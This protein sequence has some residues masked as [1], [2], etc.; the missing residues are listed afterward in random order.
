MPHLQA[1]QA[2][3]AADAAVV[4][5][6]AVDHQRGA[7][8]Q[9]ARGAQAHAL[10]G[11]LQL[12]RRGQAQV[13]GAALFQ[14]ANGAVPAVLA[15]PRALPRQRQLQGP[16]VQAASRLDVESVIGLGA[17]KRGIERAQAG[18]RAAVVARG[19]LHR[20]R[21]VQPAAHLGAAAGSGHLVRAHFQRLRVVVGHHFG[22]LQRAGDGGVELEL[23]GHA[24]LEPLQLR[25][26]DHQLERIAARAE[27]AAQVG[28]VAG[29]AQRGLARQEPL[30]RQAHLAAAGHRQARVFALM[31]GKI[32]RH[33]KLGR[34]LAGRGE[35]RIDAAGGNLGQARGIERGQLALE[36]VRLL[37]L[38]AELAFRGQQTRP[39]RGAQRG[40]RDRLGIDAGIGE[41]LERP[42]RQVQ[43]HALP[44]R[45]HP[46]HHRAG[47]AGA[48]QR[49]MQRG[50]VQPAHIQV[51]TAAAA[52]QRTAACDLGLAGQRHAQLRDGLCHLA[53]LDMGAHRLDRQPLLVQRTGFQVVD[54][55]VAGD[56]QRCGRRRGRRSGCGD[57]RC[58][59]GRRRRHGAGRLRAG[60]SRHAAHRPQ[61][62]MHGQVGLWRRRA[63][64]ARVD[65]IAIDQQVRERHL[66]E[67]RQ[68]DAGAQVDAVAAGLQLGTQRVQVALGGGIDGKD[69]ILPAAFQQGFGAERE[70]G[71]CAQL[72]VGRQLAVWC[73]QLVHADAVALAVAVQRA[74][75]VAEHHRLGRGRRALQQRQPLKRQGIDIDGQRQFERRGLLHRLDARLRR[76][77]LH[78]GLADAQPLHVQAPRLPVERPVAIHAVHRHARLAAGEHHVAQAQAVRHGAAFQ[79]AAE[80]AGRQPRGQRPQVAGAG[81]GVQRRHA[82]RHQRHHQQQQDAD[83]PGQ[84]APQPPALARRGR[85]RRPGRIAAGH[86]RQIVGAHAG[87]RVRR[88]RQG[89]RIRTPPPARYAAGTAAVGCRSPGPAAAGPPACASARRRPRRCRWSHRAGCRRQC[90]DPRTPPRPSP[91]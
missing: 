64:Q 21:A 34:D 27:A 2:A 56:R 24:K 6:Q 48:G 66:A 29:H 57:P 22:F 77:E 40:Q 38:Q 49:A 50:R 9:Q 18:L 58:R 67:R 81:F 5:V 51:E 85:G 32:Q 14:R 47:Q 44:A 75:Q 37:V 87:I 73:F 54:R 12:R 65:A 89:C 68:V 59:R 13:D 52:A 90:R 11:H 20:E 4:P 53:Q 19:Q 61:L 3:R 15:L 33:A 71:A 63:E 10:V 88:E 45:L 69:L 78:F 41:K 70:R 83:Q 79:P 8:Q 36:A 1:V 62:G 16:L 82:R 80:H 91:A 26:I 74:G 39:H 46:H 7:V 84:H 86:R 43:R 23:A 60:T 72:G 25:R 35:I 31:H 28:L 17:I 30:A 55:D 76:A 42:A